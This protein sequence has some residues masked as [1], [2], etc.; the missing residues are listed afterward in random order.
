MITEKTV[1]PLKHNGQWQTTKT[2]TIVRNPKEDNE[3]GIVLSLIRG[4]QKKTNCL[5]AWLTKLPLWYKQPEVPAPLCSAELLL[6][7]F[8]SATPFTLCPCGAWWQRAM[9]LPFPADGCLVSA[10]FGGGVFNYSRNRTS[11]LCYLTTGLL[12]NPNKIISIGC[13][14]TQSSSSLARQPC[15]GPVLLQKLPPFFPI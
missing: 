1:N 10:L 14:L 15:V 12:K 3:V 11:Y 8:K 13:S 4:G 5:S 9:D 6:Q 2:C 7:L